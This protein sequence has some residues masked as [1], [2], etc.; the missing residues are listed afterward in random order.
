MKLL[1]IL[2]NL[3]LL[4][5]AFAKQKKVEDTY[6][7]STLKMLVKKQVGKNYRKVTSRYS[8][9]NDSPPKK[10]Y[11]FGELINKET[12]SRHKTIYIHRKEDIGEA[13][14]F[15]FFSGTRPVR[16]D[17]IAFLVD[18]NGRISDWGHGIYNS[19]LYCF[20]LA[21]SDGKNSLRSDK[22]ANKDKSKEL[23]KSLSTIKLSSGKNLDSLRK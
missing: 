1:I 3:S 2:F 12:Y 17:M 20:G 6:N 7:I 23:L 13:S 16:Y 15:L 11:I 14:K 18:N 9:S 5:S 19:Q 10:L 8:L 22:C 21:V 4:L